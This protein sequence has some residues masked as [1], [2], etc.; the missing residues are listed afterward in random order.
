MYANDAVF[1]VKNL[2]DLQSK[3]C[4]KENGSENCC[5]KEKMVVFDMENG[6]NDYK[7]YINR[8]TPKWI[9]EFVY[10]GRMLGTWMEKF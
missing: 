9:D 3:L 8:E 7:S 10:F 2:N 1:L 5:M 4:N 6:M